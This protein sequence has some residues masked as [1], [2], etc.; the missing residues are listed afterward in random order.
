M[1]TCRSCG[2]RIAQSAMKCQQCGSHYGT[3][4]MIV[5]R[6]TLAGLIVGFGLAFV[7]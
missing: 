2:A 1:A 7:L 3:I 5:Y 6:L 4:G